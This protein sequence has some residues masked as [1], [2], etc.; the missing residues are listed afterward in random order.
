MGLMQRRIK[1]HLAMSCLCLSISVLAMSA[2]TT[3]KAW[4]NHWFFNMDNDIIVGSDGDFSNGILLGWQTGAM[5]ELDQASWLIKGLSWLTLSDRSQHYQWG[6]NIHQRMWT[7]IEIEHDFPQAYDRPYAGTLELNSYFGSFSDEFAQK[8]Q[9]SLGVIGP[10]SGAEKSQSWVHDITN[11]E[12]PNGWD[13]QVQNQFIGQL[14]YEADYLITRQPFF[15][16]TQ[17]DFAPYAQLSAGNFRSQALG[18]LSLRWG[19]NLANSFGKLTSIDGA[20]QNFSSVAQT[21]GDW[22][23]FHRIQTGY[24][25]NDLTLEGEINYESKAN[26]TH[27]QTQVLTGVVWAT[28]TWSAE[29]TVKYYTSEFETDPSDWHGFGSLSFSYLF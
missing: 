29:F 16:H 25:F 24:R 20:L 21:S 8:V 1:Q 3:S 11:S 10:A 15:K 17:W 2:L 13:Y 7:P 4:A 26:I 28:P 5:N 12:K 27:H 19:S 23:V 6:Y 9:L 14:T 18:G 22:Q